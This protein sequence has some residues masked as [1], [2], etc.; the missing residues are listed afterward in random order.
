MGGRWS[1]S[2]ELLKSSWGVLRS[3][4]SLVVFPIVSA[5]VTII[6]IAALAIPAY[7]LT[8]AS[9]GHINNP[10]LCYIFFF[11]FYF[12]GYFI[13]FF[14]NTGLIACAQECLRGNDPDFSYGFSIAMENLGRIAIWALISATV[15]LILKAIRERFG[16]LGAILTGLLDVAWNLLTFFVIPVFI[17]QGFGV[18]DSIK[19][20][21]KIFKRTWGENMI[22]RFSLGLIFFLLALIGLVPLALVIMTKSIVL[23]V[24]IGAVVLAYWMILGVRSASLS[25]LLSTALYD[26]AVTGQVPP[27]YNPATI[28]AAFQQKPAGRFSLR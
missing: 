14:F 16:F 20:S 28:T 6:M 25:G 19:E 15:G 13:V 23:I 8:G 5:V 22:A 26:Y 24:A 3:H 12:V 21:A 10:V 2:V 7:L 9:K 17:F 27:A 11:I 4:K 1:N 18:I